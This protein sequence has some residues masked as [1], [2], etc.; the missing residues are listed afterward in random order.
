M[1]VGLFVAEHQ[2]G[3]S[4]VLALYLSLTIWEALLGVQSMTFGSAISTNVPCLVLVEA[5]Q[6]NG[7][8]VS[9]SLL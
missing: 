9:G 4:V 6:R 2:V 1:R 3:H 5:Q 7:E 8:S